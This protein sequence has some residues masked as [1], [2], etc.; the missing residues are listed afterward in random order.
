MP[1]ESDIILSEEAALILNVDRSTVNRKAAK[2]KIPF[3]RKLD[4]PRGAYIF[5]RADI[6]A[7]LTG[8]KAS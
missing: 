3:V 7:L 8:E 4:G 6:E 5:R 2:G 1:D